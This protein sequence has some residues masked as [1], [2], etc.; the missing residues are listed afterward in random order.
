M[1]RNADINETTRLLFTLIEVLKAVSSKRPS[2]G[3]KGSF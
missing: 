2:W 3:L 1:N